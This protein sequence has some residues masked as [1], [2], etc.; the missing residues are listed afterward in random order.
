MLDAERMN[1]WLERLP[2]VLA[3]TAVVLQRPTGVSR[4]CRLISRLASRLGQPGAVGGTNI[5]LASRGELGRRAFADSR[6]RGAH[7]VLG[8]GDHGL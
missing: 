8:P 2:A 6:R 3:V 4:E 1:N 5:G 7:Q